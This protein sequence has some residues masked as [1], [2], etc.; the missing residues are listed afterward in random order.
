MRAGV[1]PDPGT[2]SN[3]DRIGGLPGQGYRSHRRQHLHRAA[4]ACVSAQNF[5]TTTGTLDRRGAPAGRRTQRRDPHRPRRR[6]MGR[7]RHDSSPQFDH[8]PA[9]RGRRRSRPDTTRP[10][11]RRPTESRSVGRARHRVDEAAGLPTAGRQ[12]AGRHHRRRPRAPRR[13][14][15]ARGHHAVRAGA[16]DHAAMRGLAPGTPL[17]PTVPIM[18]ICSTPTERGKVTADAVASP[19]DD[20]TDRLGVARCALS[21]GCVHDPAP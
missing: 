10:R 7:G 4:L 20:A 2:S 9:R 12:R 5:A 16:P 17:L 3:D 8:S 14:G 15:Y 1:T 13:R 21:L 18:R 11:T 19:H 6:P